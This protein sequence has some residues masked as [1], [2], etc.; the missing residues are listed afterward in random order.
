MNYQQ[1]ENLSYI[2]NTLLMVS[3]KGEDTVLMAECLKNFRN[4]ILE[5][6]KELENSK[7]KLENS[8]K[9]V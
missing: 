7:K 5:A 1:L 4:F 8:N 3:T 9:E 6:Q 2:Y